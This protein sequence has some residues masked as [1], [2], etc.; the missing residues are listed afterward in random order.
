MSTTPTPN[1][2][3]TA[4]AHAFIEHFNSQDHDKLAGTLNFPHVRFALGT[5]TTIA[6]HQDFVER[7]RAG[8][9]RLLAEG[10][11][12]TKLRNLQVIQSGPDKV[13]LQLLVDR[14][15]EDGTIYNTFDTL[16]ICSRQDDKWGIQFRSS[17]LH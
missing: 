2:A 5:F 1:E 6:T 9:A 13:H 4:A 17:F 11:D 3:A 10:W 7:S 16:W 15:R 8:N 12:H 14:C